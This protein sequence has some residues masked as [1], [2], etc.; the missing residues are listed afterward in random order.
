MDNTIR[1]ALIISTA[2]H[3][4]I[5]SPF[6]GM[7]RFPD[8]RQDR[9]ESIVV[10]YVIIKE[11]A[12]A[13]VTVHE[14]DFKIPQE[15]K[16]TPKT[17]LKRMVDIKPADTTTVE[18]K[19]DGALKRVEEAAKKQEEIKARELAVKQAR[20]KSTKD[21]TNYY[22]LIREKIRRRLKDNYRNYSK[23][24]EVHT[25]FTLNSD[26]T[27]DG[28]GIEESGYTSDESLVKIAILSIKEAAPFRPFPK[29]LS[30]PKMS[31]NLVISFKRQ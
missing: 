2:V 11:A 9:K 22:Y 13:E 23:E 4:C 16:E 14:V 15:P 6:A 29:A 28:I 5:L 25:V 26:G 30:L 19:D 20:I 17:E 10:D 12:N 27:V 8:W 21:Y 3:A 18:A 7:V 31:F 24:A 1:N